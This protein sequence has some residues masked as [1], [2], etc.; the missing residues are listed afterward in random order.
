[1]K[2]STIIIG[3]LAGA[4]LL[5]KLVEAKE[6]TCS[7]VV[8]VEGGVI[9]EAPYTP[10]PGGVTHVGG[11]LI[12]NKTNKKIFYKP[13]E[14][15]IPELGAVYTI[16]P[17]VDWIETNTLFG[18]PICITANIPEDIR[19]ALHTKDE[20]TINIKKLKYKLMFE[21]YSETECVFSGKLTFQNMLRG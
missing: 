5:S 16:P 6:D 15:E 21:D 19:N 20:I 14:L 12:K 13:T 10:M 2:T 8:G 4:Y 3:G 7:D 9:I 17:L 11:I 1:M 18:F